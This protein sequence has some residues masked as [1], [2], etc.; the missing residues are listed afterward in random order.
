MPQQGITRDPKGDTHGDGA[1][2][3]T[4]RCEQRPVKVSRAIGD[5]WLVE[6]GLAA[7]DQVIVEGLQKIRPGVRRCR[8]TEAG[9]PQPAPAGRR[10]R[11][12]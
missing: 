12:A 2:A 10:R 8:P 4:A 9:A 5:Q 7:G 3:P 6:D 11:S 1:S